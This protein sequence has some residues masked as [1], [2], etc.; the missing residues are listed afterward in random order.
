MK[1]PLWGFL[2]FM[3]GI[4]AIAGI[5][6]FFRDF[7]ADTGNAIP[8]LLL[9]LVC[10]PLA[11]LCIKKGFKSKNKPLARAQKATTTSPSKRAAPTISSEKAAIASMESQISR[12]LQE[13]VTVETQSIDP[14]E[15]VATPKGAE[16]SYL[17]A[18]A[19]KF[20]DGKTT[21]FEV[22]R[23]YADSAFGR[24]VCPA[25]R[26]LLNGGYLDLARI[27][28]SIN[29]KT[30][31]ELKPIL[32]AHNLKISGKKA[33]LVHRLVSNLS[34]RE[35]AYLF[36]TRVYEI[37]PKG[38]KALEPYSII[39]A[40]TKYGTDFPYYRLLKEKESTP[41]DED[42][43]ILLRMFDKDLNSA[44]S[45]G[46]K[47]TYRVKSMEKAHLLNSIGRPEDA[48]EYYCLSFFLFWY[49]NT[50]ELKVT[51]TFGY[52]YDAKRIDAC[53]AECGYSLEETLK[54]F[55]R[56]LRKYNPFGLC[57]SRN[58]SIAQQVFRKALSV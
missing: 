10:I 50:F 46:N 31:P 44:Q 40:N 52:E 18:Q 53:G 2:A 24:N 47:E 49:R 6:A 37:T 20:W 5:N 9:G 22:P 16:I 13:S 1:K 23:Y 26:R 57:T 38:E 21:D 33:E 4:T 58:I 29:L 15:N 27:E 25:L 30:V 54:T 7:S 3:C 48:I 51:S 12:M 14:D 8:N 32:T 35:L 42:I 19:L 28:R 56:T 55:Q 43:D 45:S 17:D 34:D 11:I 41:L 39:F 36:P